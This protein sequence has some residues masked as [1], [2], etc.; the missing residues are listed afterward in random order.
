MAYPLPNCLINVR[1]VAELITCPKKGN[2]SMKHKILMW[3]LENGQNRPS[4]L[5][6][7]A[8]MVRRRKCHHK[9][10]YTWF[11]IFFLW[12]VCSSL[13]FFLQN[14]PPLNISKLSNFS[15]QDVFTLNNIAVERHPEFSNS[16]FGASYFERNQN[17]KFA[18]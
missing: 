16:N 15:A 3:Q 2:H 8:E 6:E 12:F 17:P 9:K 7:N 4:Q 10:L 18:S 1:Q 11:C 5:S 14:M 13:Q